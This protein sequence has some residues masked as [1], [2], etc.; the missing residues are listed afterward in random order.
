MYFYIIS[1][2]FHS[3]PDDA[4]ELPARGGCSALPWPCGAD[5]C[6][7]AKQESGNHRLISA[8]ISWAVIQNRPKKI[9]SKKHSKLWADVN[10]NWMTCNWLLI[11]GHYSGWLLYLY[12]LLYSSL[13]NIILSHY[14]S[15]QPVPFECWSWGVSSAASTGWSHPIPWSR[16]DQGWSDDPVGVCVLGKPL[17]IR[18]YWHIYWHIYI[19]ILTIYQLFYS[20]FQN[21][22]T[23]WT[24]KWNE[25]TLVLRVET[26]RNPIPQ[27]DSELQVSVGRQAR[28]TAPSDFGGGRLSGA[29]WSRGKSP[30]ALWGAWGWEHRG[31]IWWGFFTL[32]A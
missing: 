13:F 22:W 28:A 32:A 24:V 25:I 18:L 3:R 11:I 1:H 6:G 27:S 15:D 10:E 19:Y 9:K 12:N 30:G 20:E 14:W 21:H 4:R 7:G 5:R 16:K 31:K 23:Y 29:G 26:C 8:E 17:T 2:P